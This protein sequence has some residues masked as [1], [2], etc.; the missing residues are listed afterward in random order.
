MKR[1]KRYAVFIV[2][3]MAPAALDYCVSQCRNALFLL[4]YLMQCFLKTVYGPLIKC[5]V[6][7][8]GI[9]VRQAF[10]GFNC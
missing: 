8:S 1:R 10:E 6:N 3:K 9:Y 4:H 7:Y 2:I 5:V